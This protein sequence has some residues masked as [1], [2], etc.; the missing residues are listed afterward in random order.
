MSIYKIVIY[1]I[2]AVKALKATRKEG[3]SL[4]LAPPRKRSKKL[5]P[6][7]SIKFS[8][9]LLKPL[10]TTDHGRFCSEESLDD[11]LPNNLV[12]GS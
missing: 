6:W 11:A 1:N 4:Y 9:Q 10:V 3:L 7:C 5:W 8:L 2:G 12:T